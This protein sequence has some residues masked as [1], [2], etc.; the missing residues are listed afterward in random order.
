MK[1]FSNKTI[2]FAGGG[3]GGPTTPLI[4]V[5]S[6][7]K[8][9]D[10][11]ARVIFIGTKN[12]PEKVWAEELGLDFHSLPVAKLR[13]YFSLENFFDIFKFVYSFFKA[14]WLMVEHR[15][16][17]VVGAGGFISVPVMWA[18]KLFGR[19]VLIHQQDVT[20]TLSNRLT[21]RFADTITLTFP[22]QKEYFARGIVTGNPVREV[23]LQ[24]NREQALKD[25]GLEAGRQTILV[26]GGGSGALGLDRV[27]LSAVPLLTGS[28]Y[29]VIHIV[30]KN[31]PPE[32]EFL[33]R[34]GKGYVRKEVLSGR[35]MAGAF[36]ASDLVIC[37]AGLA[38]ISELS[39]L[40]KASIIVPM[41][42]SHQEQN[43][44][45]LLQ[46]NAAEVLSQKE[47]T[48][49]KLFNAVEDVLKNEKKKNELQKNISQIMLGGG[50]DTIAQLVY[51]LLNLS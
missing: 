49:E 11:G 46:K 51:K 25:F 35:A 36:A 33:T 19:R 41:P 38:T 3:T 39:A 14:C 9:N 17:V 27:V 23:L 32:G 8:K 7:I 28:G 13:R 45:L 10:P 22:E 48:A 16:D 20:P 18:A 30:G 42:D 47:L 2:A 44:E 24:G 40:Q 26:F 34:I 37:R 31:S 5:A 43:A 6:V 21:H 15:I 12:G 29:Q 50:A 4:A 1:N